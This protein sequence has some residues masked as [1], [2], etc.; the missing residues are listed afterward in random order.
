LNSQDLK[1]QSIVEECFK[2]LKIKALL[3]SVSNGE[4]SFGKED[5]SFL[6]QNTPHKALFFELLNPSNSRTILL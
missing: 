1:N 2:W 6:H 3:R 4:G 5:S